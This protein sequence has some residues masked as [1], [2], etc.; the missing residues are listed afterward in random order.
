[1]CRYRSYVVQTG[2]SHER[3]RRY[4][5]IFSAQRTQ[6]ETRVDPEFGVYWAF[7]NP[8]SRACITNELLADLRS[9]VDTLTCDG[10]WVTEGGQRHQIRYGVIASRTP[11]I[12][13]LGGDLALFRSAIGSQD[14]MH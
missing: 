7:M 14:R 6:V 9:V 10:G 1:M 13:N 2:A 3:H 5:P 8:K 4:S 11:R 12:F